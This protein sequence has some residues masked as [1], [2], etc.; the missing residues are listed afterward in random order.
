MKVGN[1]DITYLSHVCFLFVSPG[2]TRV[3]T[4]VMYADG[5]EW[6]GHT[7][8]YLSP[9]DVPLDA[10]RACDVI[11][12][13]HIHGDHYDPD[14]IIAIHERTG[15]D[16][17]AP[18]DV[19]EDLAARGVDGKHLKEATEGGV[20]RCGDLELRS[21][22]GYDDSFD[23]RGRPNKYSLHLTARQR[24]RSSRDGGIEPVRRRGTKC[25]PGAAAGQHFSDGL[26][27]CGETTFFYS[28][29]CHELPPTMIG[30]RVDGMCMWPHP[31][32][33]KMRALAT[34]I[35]YDTFIMMHCDRFDPGDFFC[36]MDCEEQRARLERLVPGISVVIPERATRV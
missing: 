10:I 17:L 31:D 24:S 15:A 6:K 3:L 27:T 11:F 2:G 36:N 30:Q 23:D 34:Q 28:G 5:F 7:E 22:C 13:S 8:R 4:D 25:R 21:Y 12:V 26:L 32:D 14:A 1:L 18:A 20:Y 29:D 9:P 19:L 33:D 35:E 16:F